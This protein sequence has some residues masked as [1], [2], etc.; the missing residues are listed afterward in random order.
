[1]QQSYT[2]TETHCCVVCEA[3]ISVLVPVGQLRRSVPPNDGVQLGLRATL[4]F[5][6]QQHHDEDKIQRRTCSLGPRNEEVHADH[7]QLIDCNTSPCRSLSAD[8]LQHKSV[9]IMIS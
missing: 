3:T 8:P 1:M 7:D 2:G 9:Q 5:R 6:V 4:D